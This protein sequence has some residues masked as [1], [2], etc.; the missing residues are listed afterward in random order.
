MFRTKKDFILHPF[1]MR[2]R[3]CETISSLLVADGQSTPRTLPKLKERSGLVRST[4]LRHI[5]HLDRLGLINKEQI[6]RDGR[7][8]RPK[9]LYSASEPTIV[10]EMTGAARIT[11]P[12]PSLKMACRFRSRATCKITNDPCIL[13]KCP[14]VNGNSVLFSP[15]HES[16]SSKMTG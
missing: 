12:F 2:D 10:A 9:T 13:S 11:I 7:R 14:I 1:Q 8:G 16:S 4:L 3:Y 6:P 15:K 5:S